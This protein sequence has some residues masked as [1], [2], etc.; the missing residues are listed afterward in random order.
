MAASLHT[1]QCASLRR[2]TRAVPASG[3]SASRGDGIWLRRLRRRGPLLQVLPDLQG[4]HEEHRR[5]IYL[6]SRPAAASS[7]FAPTAALDALDAI[8][9]RRPRRTTTS[10]CTIRRSSRD[11]TRSRRTAPPRAREGRPA[12]GPE[13]GL[14][15]KNRCTLVS[16]SDFRV[17]Y[18]KVEAVG[19]R[20]T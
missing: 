3:L 8:A 13:R 15:I 20:A 2:L 1:T 4:V 14:L 12:D 10:A 17:Q 5:Q 9:A 11:G 18:T 16:Q 7:P 19:A 6:R